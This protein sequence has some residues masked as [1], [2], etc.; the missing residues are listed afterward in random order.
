MKLSNLIFEL[1][2]MMDKFGDCNVEV[3][4]DDSDVLETWDIN[5]VCFF[6]DG[7]RQSVIIVEE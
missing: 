3:A 6:K 7:E 1:Q 2:S 4:N 5:R